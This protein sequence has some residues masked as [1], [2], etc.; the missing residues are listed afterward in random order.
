LAL[1]EP[2]QIFLTIRLLLF[3]TEVMNVITAAE[4]AEGEQ[5]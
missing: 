5:P 3:E 4:A 1:I 2:R